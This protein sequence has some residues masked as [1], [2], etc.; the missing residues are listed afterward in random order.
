M[1][2]AIASLAGKSSHATRC[3]EKWIASKHEWTAAT[4]W[5]ILAGG[6][7]GRPADAADDIASLP[8][9]TFE[10]FLERIEA[11]IHGSPNRVRHSMNGALIAIGLRNDAL[12]K[13]ALAAAK[14]IGPV[15]V[16]HG[17]TSCKTPDAEA[18]IRKAVE[19]R[20]KKTSPKKKTAGKRKT[21]PISV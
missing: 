18:Y 19:Q 21:S 4:G 6:C 1:L 14:R 2:D 3:L 5:Q 10:A 17:D 11:K 8:D 12:R 20:R 13:L 9:S 16:D 7:C 15:E